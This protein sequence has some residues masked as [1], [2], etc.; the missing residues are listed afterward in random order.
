MAIGPWSKPKIEPRQ[1]TTTRQLAGSL[2]LIAKSQRLSQEGPHVTLLH[3]GNI[4]RR[5]GR[6]HEPA[7]STAFWPEVDDI[8]GRFDHAEVVFDEDDGVS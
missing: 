7:P 6:N 2:A 3:R 1:G 8:V 4:F 5:P